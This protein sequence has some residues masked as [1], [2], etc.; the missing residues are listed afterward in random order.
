MRSIDMGTT[1][2]AAPEMQNSSRNAR[3][4]LRGVETLI[5]APMSWLKNTLQ[6][7]ISQN[8]EIIIARLVRWIEPY[9]LWK[10][11]MLLP[12]ET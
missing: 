11:T 8:Q 5:Q 6:L 1:V 9:S 10:H 4:T 2:V 7:T 12:N 3:E